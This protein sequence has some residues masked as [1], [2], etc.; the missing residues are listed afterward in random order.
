MHKLVLAS[1]SLLVLTNM[2][3]LSGVAYNRSDAPLASLEMTERELPLHQPSGINRDDSG[4][5]LSLEWQVLTSN[6]SASYLPLYY[7][8]PIW[9][10][11]AKLKTLGFDMAALNSDVAGVRDKT[12]QLAQKVILVLEF[13]GQA[14]Q[15]AIARAERDVDRIPPNSSV[16]PNE[17]LLQRQYKYEQI[18]R[19]LEVSDT[20][21]FV[22]DAGLD[23]EA[24]L[25]QY[26]QRTNHFLVQGEIG[27][28]YIKSILKGSIQRLY[29]EQIHA[30]LPFSKE[31]RKLAVGKNPIGQNPTDW[32]EPLA[33]GYTVRLNF[34]KRFEPWIESVSPIGVL[35]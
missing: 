2:V 14:Y 22:I 17:N 11:D 24:L 35:E 27:V 28:H 18:L 34:G 12:S 6:E 33:P 25:H 10:D 29:I 31:L 9:L 3:V 19:N 4:T 7:E 1:I 21:L 16:F 5:A 8:T 23:E 32:V 13:D 15:K 26:G 30:P 20:R